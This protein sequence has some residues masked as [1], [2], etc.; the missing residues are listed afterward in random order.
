MTAV[1]D[2]IQTLPSVARSTRE[3]DLRTKI[4]LISGYISVID[5]MKSSMNEGDKS[6]YDYLIRKLMMD[7]YR[8]SF[9]GK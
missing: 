8:Q 1:L 5:E 9:V 4:K 7:P 6:T 2:H 3:S